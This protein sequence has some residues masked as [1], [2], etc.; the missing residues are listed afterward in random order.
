MKLEE[1]TLQTIKFG[2]QSE[3]HFY[4]LVDLNISPE[5]MDV[6]K[7]KL[8]DPR[9]LDLE[10]RESGCLMMFTGDEIRELL[11]RGDL[12]ETDL[13]QSLFSLAEKEG[14]IPKS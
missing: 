10:F 5:G 1:T 13:H 14:V 8:T 9:S 12:A 6:E 2:D 3:D 4:C 7:I 11:N